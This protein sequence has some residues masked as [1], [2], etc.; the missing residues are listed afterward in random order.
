M[1]TADAA[2]VDNL[3]RA[4]RDFAE[5]DISG[6]PLTRDLLDLI[7]CLVAAV[8]TTTA[9]AE[10]VGDVLDRLRTRSNEAY[11]SFRARSA[12]ARPVRYGVSGC[13]I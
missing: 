9:D 4:V 1:S 10:Y 2:A 3:L 11:E 8:T 7:N 12:Q 5:D 6:H 13:M